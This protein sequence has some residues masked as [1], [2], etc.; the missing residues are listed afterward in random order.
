MLK[1]AAAILALVAWPTASAFAQ[2]DYPSRPVTIVL[3]FP[4]GGSIDLTA[5][6]VAPALERIFRQP[7][8]IQNR[9]GA[10]GA[11]G[12]HVAA[13]AQPDGYTLTIATTQ[14]ATL[15]AVDHVMGKK[16]NFTRDQFAPIALLS[17]DPSLLFV[18][19]E[20]PWTSLKALVDDAKQRPNGIVF[21]SGGLYGATH[22]P[23]EMFLKAVGAK[24]RHLPTSGGGPALTAVLGNNAALLAAHPGVG[25]PQVKAGKLRPL[26]SFGARRIAQFPDVPTF[27]EL[28][29]DIEYYQ[30]IGVFAPA[31]VPAAIVNVVRE[32]VARAAKERDFLDAMERAGSGV[33]YMDADEFRVF[34]DKDSKAI[35]DAVNAIGKL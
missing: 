26:A 18:N 1:L 31:K 17:S 19:T 21:A 4:P 34:W 27:K 3:A 35:E 9:G 30:W 11:I 13:T 10:G 29:Y 28:G 20:Q 15:P 5:R 23:I 16:P 24:M 8:V 25:G 22:I 6:A 2:N 14:F 33:H 32:A 12:S 7:V